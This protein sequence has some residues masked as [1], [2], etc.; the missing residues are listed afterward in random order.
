MQFIWIA[1]GFLPLSYMLLILMEKVLLFSLRLKQVKPKACIVHFALCWSKI[2][3]RF[4]NLQ[5]GPAT[6]FNTSW[7][8]E[9]NIS[10]FKFLHS[11]STK[12]EKPFLLTST[13]CKLHNNKQTDISVTLCIIF[14]AMMSMQESWLQHTR[15]PETSVIVALLFKFRSYMSSYTPISRFYHF[16]I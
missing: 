7:F 6:L 5:A 3:V 2:F 14:F 9:K 16:L 1:R 10:L 12:L 13:N 15:L 11:I 8:S 4:T